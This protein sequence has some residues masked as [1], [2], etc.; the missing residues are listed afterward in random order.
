M[1]TEKHWTDVASKLLK[2]RTIK[3]VRYMTPEEAE[4]LGWY[5]RSIVFVLDNK[6]ICFVAADDEGND[7]GSLF[8]GTNGVLPTLNL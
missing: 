1:T 4:G 5:K 8:Y 6:E 3:A 7:G 2:G